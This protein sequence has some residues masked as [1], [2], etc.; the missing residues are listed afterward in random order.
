M[1]ITKYLVAV[2]M[3]LSLT[4]AVYAAPVGLTSEADATKA[5]LWADENYGLSVGFISDFVDQRKIDIGGG[6]FEVDVM[7]VKA[8]A[9]MV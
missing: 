8:V 7:M 2:L 4:V 9:A 5:E 6:E 3:V 1:R